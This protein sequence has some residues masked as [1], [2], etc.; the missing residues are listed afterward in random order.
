M[1]VA[2]DFEDDFAISFLSSS[3]EI[4]T[5]LCSG[6]NSKESC[7]ASDVEPGRDVPLMGFA[8]QDVHAKEEVR[9]GS[10]LYRVAHLLVD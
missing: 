8:I 4:S 1:A 3:M 9:R 2:F 7:R 6:R 10:N 5:M